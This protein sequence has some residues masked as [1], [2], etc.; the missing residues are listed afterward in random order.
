MKLEDWC[1]DL[2]AVL[3]KWAKQE[4]GIIKK[5]TKRLIKQGYSKKDIRLIVSNEIFDRFAPMT[6]KSYKL[7]AAIKNNIED[8]EYCREW[9]S[10]QY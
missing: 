10:R 9:L 1:Y 2:I 3:P 5:D 6:T 4:V 8:E 7:R